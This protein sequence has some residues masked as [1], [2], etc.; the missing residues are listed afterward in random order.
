MHRKCEILSKATEKRFVLP[1]MT[2][3]SMWHICDVFTKVQSVNR[4]ASRRFSVEGAGGGGFAKIKWLDLPTL[5]AARPEALHESASPNDACISQQSQFCHPPLIWS[6][7]RFLEGKTAT[8]GEKW[9]YYADRFVG[10][11]T[12]SPR[13]YRTASLRARFA[14][15]QDFSCWSLTNSPII[16]F[17]FLSL[18]WQRQI[19][20]YV[21]SLY[22]FAEHRV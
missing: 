9:P 7:S 15:N 2:T 16:L 13:S 18:D 14:R 8:T 20:M 11:R 6:A 19:C 1:E 12:W 17:R 5:A 4:S 21:F 10:T 3:Y 22:K